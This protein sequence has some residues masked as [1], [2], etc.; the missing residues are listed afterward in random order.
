MAVGQLAHFPKID[1][2]SGQGSAVVALAIVVVVEEHN[3]SS[4]SELS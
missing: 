3:S 1:V 4:A 2:I